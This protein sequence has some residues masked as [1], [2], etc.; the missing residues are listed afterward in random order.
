[1]NYLH[2][3]EQKAEIVEHKDKV[4]TDIT[5][6]R[7]SVILWGNCPHVI[8]EKG[9]PAM[10]TDNTR[11]NGHNMHVN[12]GG[13]GHGSHGHNNNHNGPR[14]DNSRERA[15]ERGRDSRERDRPR[16]HG[17]ANRERSGEK[18][19]GHVNHNHPNRGRSRDGGNR[20]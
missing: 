14:R 20:R 3:D 17:N 10:L 19:L 7:I 15:R 1:M 13:H 8:E 9:S 18:I 11:G 16:D 5:I 2:P 4:H 12:R 6:G